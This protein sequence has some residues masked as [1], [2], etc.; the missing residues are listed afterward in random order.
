[1]YQKQN[2]FLTLIGA[3]ILLSLLYEEIRFYVEKPS[4][5]SIDKKALT[6]KDVPDLALRV[7]LLSI[8]RN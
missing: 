3:L 8:F 4:S 1:M 6:G 5:T 7:E 2:V